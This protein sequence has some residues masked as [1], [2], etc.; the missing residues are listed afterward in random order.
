MLW[1]LSSELFLDD[2]DD[3]DEDDDDEEP[4]EGGFF[5]SLLHWKKE[6]LLFQCNIIQLKFWFYQVSW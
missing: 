5:S 1:I 2:D 6:T 3:D 4:E